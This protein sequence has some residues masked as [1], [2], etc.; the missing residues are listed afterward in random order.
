[1]SAAA[2]RT[3][4]TERKREIQSNYIYEPDENV[5]KLNSRWICALGRL[6]VIVEKKWTRIEE[7]DRDHR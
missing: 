2:R 3:T 1:M 7:R 5:L 4:E 6:V